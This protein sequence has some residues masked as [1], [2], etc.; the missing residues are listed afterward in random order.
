MKNPY[1]QLLATA[2][3]FSLYSWGFPWQAA[4]MGMSS[5]S[6]ALGVRKHGPSV[7][8]AQLACARGCLCSSI[9][10][11]REGAPQQATGPPRSQSAKKLF[12]LGST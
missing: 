4:V 3:N 2:T 1:F 8:Y 6:S 10:T 9:K 7:S 5:L 12:P 11:R